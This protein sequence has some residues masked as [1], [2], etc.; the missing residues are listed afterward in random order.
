MK[1]DG[2]FVEI[3]RD[4]QGKEG[5]RESNNQNKSYFSCDV[6]IFSLWA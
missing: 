1:Y 2:I 6:K 3:S 5:I 4:L